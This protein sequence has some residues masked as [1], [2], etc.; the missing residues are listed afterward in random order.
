MAEAAAP[1]PA[2]AS[3]AEAA[4]GAMAAEVSAG[5]AGAAADTAERM[6]MEQRDSVLS[7]CFYR[8]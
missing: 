6:G 5:A 2:V 1:A 3:A 7:R 8:V 4:A